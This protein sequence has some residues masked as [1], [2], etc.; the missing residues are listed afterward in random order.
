MYVPLKCSYCAHRYSEGVLSEMNQ[1][2][3]A[4]VREKHP[5]KWARVTPRDCWVEVATTAEAAG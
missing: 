1:E 4:H 3:F 5:E 2:V